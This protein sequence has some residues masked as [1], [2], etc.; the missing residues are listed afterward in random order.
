MD[1][2]QDLLQ[3]LVCPKC[4]GP[5]QLDND[6][7]LLC[8]ACSLRY[9]VRDGLPVMLIDEAEEVELATS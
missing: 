1:I 8:E 9:P 3:W 6:G 5:V 7:N 4:K 2:D